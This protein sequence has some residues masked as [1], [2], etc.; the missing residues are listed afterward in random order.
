MNELFP[1]TE[2]QA[3]VKTAWNSAIHKRRFHKWTT[4]MQHGLRALLGQRTLAEILAAIKHY[5]ASK[6]HRQHRHLECRAWL[7]EGKANDWCEKAA[8]A[9]E[10]AQWQDKAKDT[11]VDTLA[12]DL[13]EQMRLK[14][15]AET[16][17]AVFEAMAPAEQQA[18][19]EQ[20]NEENVALGGRRKPPKLLNLNTHMIREHVLMILRRAAT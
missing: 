3:A 4:E 20:A 11:R 19:L 15:E 1:I 18:M 13:A 9:A 17:L 8:R 7:Q 10:D 6:W 2:A 16:L 12:S 14:S 5:G